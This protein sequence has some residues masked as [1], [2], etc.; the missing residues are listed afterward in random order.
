M[1]PRLVFLIAIIC[2]IISNA[3]SAHNPLTDDEKIETILGE[4]LEKTNNDLDDAQFTR[5][6]KAR[7]I[8]SN[9]ED[10]Q[11]LSSHGRKT[12]LSASQ[13]TSMCETSASMIIET[14][15]MLDSKASV[16]NGA[17]YLMVEKIDSTNGKLSVNELHQSCARACC[18]NEDGCDTALLSLEPGRVC[19]I[20]FIQ[21][22]L[23][24]FFGFNFWGYI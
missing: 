1:K 2:L 7:P 13:S 5:D 3:H 24:F 19:C 11:P 20:S 22:S 15:K 16:T 12:F 6:K 10:Q 18:E 14:D 23:F 21:L 17:L 9:N 4:L 8:N